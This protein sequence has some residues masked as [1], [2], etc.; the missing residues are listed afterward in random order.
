MTKLDCDTYMNLVNNNVMVTLTEPYKHN[1]K[2][3]VCGANVFSKYIDGKGKEHFCCHG[4]QCV[5][6]TERS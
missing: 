1:F 4:C 3:V 6:D 5:Y 2:C